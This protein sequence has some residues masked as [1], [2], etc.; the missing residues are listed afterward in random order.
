MTH[1]RT[2]L[3]RK[4]EPS[5]IEHVF[6]IVDVACSGKA[7]GPRESARVPS[8]FYQTNLLAAQQL[9]EAQVTP[10]LQPSS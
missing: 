1:Q 5:R 9:G 2:E 10:R 4:R 3:C 7:R 8:W 6:A